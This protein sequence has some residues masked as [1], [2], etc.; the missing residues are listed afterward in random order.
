MNTEIVW[1]DYGAL[2]GGLARMMDRFKEEGTLT[3]DEEEDAYIR[4]NPNA[5]LLGL[6]YDQRMRAEYAFMAPHRLHE[7]LGHLNMKRI[8]AMNPERLREIFAEKPAIH[9]FTNKMAD[10][11]HTIA[12]ILATE[13]NGD[14]SGL[15]NDGADFATI[16]KRIRKLPGFGPQKAMKLR[17]VLHYFDYRDFSDQ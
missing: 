13:F 14:A 3:G 12:S 4:S 8:A 1:I 5:A 10:L 15:W 11:T 17:F 9:R 2:E 6:L 7:R 16:E